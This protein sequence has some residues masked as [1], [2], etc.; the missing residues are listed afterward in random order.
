MSAVFD[1]FSKMVDDSS[2]P[3][4]KELLEWVVNVKGLD[5]DSSIMAI[6]D[7]ILASPVASLSVVSEAL[8]G[9][10]GKNVVGRYTRTEDADAKAGAVRRL[11]LDDTHGLTAETLLH[12]VRYALSRLK[13]GASNKT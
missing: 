6:V 10:D 12:E 9:T 11:S 1:G 3:S 2:A 8:L 4:V 7:S 13:S 5:G